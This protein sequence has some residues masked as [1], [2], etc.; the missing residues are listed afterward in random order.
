MKFSESLDLP[1]IGRLRPY[2][3]IRKIRSNGSNGNEV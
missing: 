3:V 2:T 1:L